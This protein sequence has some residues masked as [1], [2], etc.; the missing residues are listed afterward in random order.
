M[1][2]FTYLRTIYR[3]GLFFFISFLTVENQMI[4]HFNVYF[5]TLSIIEV[6]YITL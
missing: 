6:T 1:W 4:I 2:I 5:W 3:K